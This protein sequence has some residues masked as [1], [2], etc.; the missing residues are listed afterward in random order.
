M[1]AVLA[2]TGPI[3][4]LI[5]VGFGAVRLRV[6]APTDMRALG[7]FVINFALPAMLFAAVSSGS[8]AQTVRLDLLLPYALGSLVVAGGV[9]ALR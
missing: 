7:V 6:L 2:I 8:F 3:F 1:L 4:I 9:V 5:A